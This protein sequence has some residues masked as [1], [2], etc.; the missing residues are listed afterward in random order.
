MSIDKQSLIRRSIIK[1]S[2][3][4]PCLQ[5]SLSK[6][7]RVLKATMAFFMISGVMTSGLGI[8]ANDAVGAG[9]KKSHLGGENCM[10]KAIKSLASLRTKV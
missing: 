8:S 10:H 6:Q 1:K 9:T 4:S 3:S 2:A 7:S 5:G